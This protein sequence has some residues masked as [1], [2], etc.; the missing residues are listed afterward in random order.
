[1]KI[2]DLLDKLDAIESQPV[3]EM[4][5][6]GTGAGAIAGSMGGGNGFGPSPFGSHKIKVKPIKKLRKR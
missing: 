4:T 2:R 3:Y 5:A 1:M 6:G